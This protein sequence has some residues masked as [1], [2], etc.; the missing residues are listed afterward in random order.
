MKVKTGLQAASP[1]NK[2]E[3]VETVQ[4]CVYKIRK[5]NNF[6]TSCSYI[7]CKV[8]LGSEYRTSDY[9][10]FNSPVSTIQITSSKLKDD[11]NT[12]QAFKPKFD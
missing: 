11:Q 2:I 3:R 9:R 4:G 10:T 8:Q 6:W 5:L 7:F 1:L 12:G